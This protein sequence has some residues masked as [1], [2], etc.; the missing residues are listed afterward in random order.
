M[1]PVRGTTYRTSVLAA[2]A[3][4]ALTVTACGGDD[5]S[6][7][8][9]ARAAPASS[10]FPAADGRTLDQLYADSNPG[11]LV[12]SPAQSVFTEGRNR[13]GFAVFTVDHQQI[14]DAD[15]AI[16]A[17][18]G[19]DAPAQGPFTARVESLATDPAFTAQTTSED[20][21]AAKAVYV[22]DLMLD[23]P[24][25][26]QLIALVRRGDE[27]SSSRLLG[28]AAVDPHDPIPALGE[29]APRVHTPTVDDVGDVSE[30]D[31][32]VP[33]DTMH[34]VDLVDALGKKPVVLEFATPA[35]CQSRVCGPVVDVA[36]QVKAD[37]PDV[38][39]IHMEIYEDNDPNQPPREQVRAYHLKSE[40][41]LFVID[42]NGRIDTR[43][44][45]AFSVDELEAAV[46]RVVG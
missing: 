39:F 38:A 34:D 14:T 25:Q 1:A 31:T 41:W 45:G 19:P 28:S 23:K 7:T 6:D 13:F 17:A 24:G 9:G 12:V 26:W 40:P 15:V 16:Y 3:V 2:A 8:D 30:I 20:P 18:P 43:I 29:Q 42:R 22:T 32:R 37:H 5:S 4:C 11:D 44:E 21:D 36:E 10:E 46:D 33:H 27:V 35:L